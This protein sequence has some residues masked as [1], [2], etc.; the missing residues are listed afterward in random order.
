MSLRCLP[1]S[2]GSIH[3]MVWEEMSFEEFQDG[4]NGGHLGCWNGTNLAVLNL[5]VTPVPPTKFQLNLTYRSRANVISRYSSWPPWQQ[6]RILEWNQF[7]NSKSSCYP[8]ASN[9]GWAKSNLPFG[10]FGSVWRL[11]KMTTMGDGGRHL[12]YQNG[13]ILA[14]LYLCVATMPSIKFQLNLTYSLGGDVV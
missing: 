2:L 11:F 13:T 14:I 5:H 12:G 6:S 9:R 1:S 3:I 10:K 8:N 7:S 4:P